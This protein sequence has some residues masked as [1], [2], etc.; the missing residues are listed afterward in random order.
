MASVGNKPPGEL[1][2]KKVYMLNDLDR[3]AKYFDVPRLIL[4]SKYEWVVL[5]CSWGSLFHFFM[6]PF[7]LLFLVC[8]FLTLV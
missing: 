6:V 8:V 2:A 4:P 7:F 1:P 5:F 3:L